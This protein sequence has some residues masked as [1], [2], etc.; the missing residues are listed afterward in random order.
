MHVM[1]DT[2][3]SVG[4]I[5]SS[6]IIYVFEWTMA[7]AICSLFISALIFFNVYP[8][9]TSTSKVLLD[10]T[11]S[12]IVHTLQRNE[13]AGMLG[14]IP[15]IVGFRLAHFWEC[16]PGRT[17]GTIHIQIAEKSP[18]GTNSYIKGNLNEDATVGNSVSKKIND[19]NDLAESDEHK[20]LHDKDNEMGNGV[21][22]QT[23]LKDRPSLTDQDILRQVSALLSSKLNI[24]ADDLTIQIERQEY[25]DRI[26]PIHHS[27][28][29]QI[30]QV[31]S[32]HNRHVL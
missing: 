31:T 8:L 9:L 3:G 12:N 11:P 1:A 5:T 23:K 25:L 13:L 7:D 16:E 22:P 26:D 21:L 20:S 17:I 30:V 15:G 10:R 24:R 28:Y 6:A 32:A 4:V 14:T 19:H 18:L 29:G 2:L 27:V